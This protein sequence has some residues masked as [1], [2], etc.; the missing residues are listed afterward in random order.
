MNQAVVV[1]GRMDTGA[2]PASGFRTRRV[3]RVPFD[4]SG[5]RQQAGVI[6]KGL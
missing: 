4:I 3:H 5:G 1:A 6:S 2:R